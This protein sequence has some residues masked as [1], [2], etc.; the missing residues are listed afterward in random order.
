MPVAVGAML[1]RYKLVAEIGNGS[2]GAVWLA[3]DTWLNKQVALKIPHNQKMD[4]TK[5]LAEPKLMAALEH[6]NIIK[7]L[8]VEKVEDTLFLVMEYVEGKSL[9]ERLNGK[10]LPVPEAVALTRGILEALAHAHQKGVVHRDLKPANILLTPTGQAK[11]TDFGT[12]HALGGGEETVAAGT[13]FYM[14]KEQLLGRVTPASDLY[15]VGVILFEMLT[16]RVPF[17]D[18]AGNKVIQK[19]LS[20]DPAP[21]PASLNPAITPGLSAVILR[22]LDRDLTRRFRKAEEFLEA[23]DA[24]MAGKAAPAAPAPVAPP[25][26]AYATFSRTV[27]RLAATL[28]KTHV[29]GFRAAWGGR[30]RADGQF[31]L[32]TGLATDGAGTVYVTDAIR[33]CVQAFDRSGKFL[34]RHGSEGGALEAGLKFTNPSAVCVDQKRRIY[35]ADTKNC[36][37]TVFTPDGETVLQFGRPLV[38][39]GLRDEAGVVGFNYPRGLAV[40]D[41]EGL[42]YVADSGNNRLRCFSLEGVPVQSFG[43]RGDRTGEFDGPL[44]LA[45]GREGRLYVA[46]STNYRIQVFDRGFRFVESLGRRGTGPAEF[47]H[48]PTHVVV[49]VND[50]LIVCDDS[51]TMRVFGSDFQP[52][53][54]IAAPRGQ[55]V[56]PKYYTAALF[57]ED[58]LAVDENGCQVHQFNWREK[59]VGR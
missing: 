34:A 27:P 50:E 33:C 9:K 43:T 55:P 40:D 1:N 17:W 38:V 14:P 18:E 23:L 35:V 15:S 25:H 58:L 39:M 47:P 4:I 30:G 42:L 21:N 49:T 28:D 22:A 54:V 41:A 24:V 36:R 44:G 20:K 56:T 7:L 32:P 46:D 37:V 48:P 19:I 29:Y 31:M 5:L 52:V 45:I 59:T 57:E 26:P 3:E 13:L 8:T 12:A 6:Q 10:P 11:I 2:F 53:G 51:D 16:G